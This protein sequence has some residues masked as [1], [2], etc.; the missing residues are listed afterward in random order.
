MR[1]E[2]RR[3][4]SRPLLP[5]GYVDGVGIAE[6]TLRPARPAALIPDNDPDLAAKFAR[7]RSL[8][9]AG[10]ASYA[11]P[12]SPGGGLSERWEEVLGLLD[13]DQVYAAG[14]LREAEKKR[15]NDAGWFV[16]PRDEP[17]ALSA[18]CSTLLH[19][20]LGV[21]SKDLEPPDGEAFVV[22]PE[23]HR[24]ILAYLPLLARFGDLDERELVCTLEGRAPSYRYNLDLSK[25]VRVERVD[26]S[27]AASDVW[28]GDLSGLVEEGEEEHALTLPDLT[29]EGLRIAPRTRSKRNRGVREVEDEHRAPMVVT[30]AHD[31]VED[32]AL[33]WNLRAEHYFAKP[34]P[35]WL[36]LDLLEDEEGASIVERALG[37][38][39]EGLAVP[40]VRKGDV[41]IVS[42]STGAGELEERIGGAFPESR[43]GVESLA[44]LFKTGCDYR[45]ATERSTVHFERGRAS[46]GPPRPEAFKNLVPYID[47]VAYDVG[48]EGM[49]LPQGREMA[50]RLGSFPYHARELVSKKGTLRFV[51]PFIKRSSEADLLD[52]RTPDGWGLLSSIFEERGY[53]IK[54]SDKAKLALGQLSRLGGVE[55]LGV[56][57]SSKVRKLLQEL[58]IRRGEKNPYVAER[59]TLPFER[60]EKA[61]GRR[62]TPDVLRWLIERRVL[63]RGTEL[64]CPNCELERWYEVDRVGEI[65]RCDGCQEDL[66]IPLKLHQTGWQYRINELY[67]RGHQ[68]GTLT[69]LLS[70]YAMH[71]A[72]GTGPGGDALG[73]YPGVKL[74][75]KKGAGVP[76]PEKEI[77]L[78]VVRGED[79]ILTECKESTGHL[80]K[81]EAEFAGQLG[82][83]V[84]LADHLG[85]SLVLGTSSTAFPEDKGPLL[86]EVPAD[87][88]V[89]IGW[90]D[91]HDLL[92]PNLYLHPL[93]HPPATGGR[94]G[95]P[96]GWEAGYL[97]WV[98]TSVIPTA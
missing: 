52:L 85:A 90:L 79:L 96:E 42:A 45:H 66:P 2:E 50:A 31:S 17:T 40:R 64:K 36:P 58:C 55:A 73:F 54:P 11:I 26:L 10:I 9:W 61:L 18:E 22:V 20:A 53:E 49:W 24:G 3:S 89:E 16:F 63:F 19:S 48:V 98:R 29:L 4:R 25:H 82:D 34:F 12:Y 93:A 75:A 41:R 60:I 69:P 77:D 94:I 39:N 81:E 30:G 70:L 8:A 92:D 84:K 6:T 33:Y 14:P 95:K 62:S 35:L 86:R 37:R 88:S 1:G 91:G 38:A 5:G 72:W 56:V 15:L 13:P 83:L 78:V 57:A 43:I 87:H 44:E 27:R 51:E 67:A 7:S 47:Y 32:F 46:I 74:E 59:K 68:Q 97:D 76:F 71:V 21:V 28:A 65:W 80:A 23:I